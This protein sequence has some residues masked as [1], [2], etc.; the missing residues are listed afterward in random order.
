LVYK[1]VF[2]LISQFTTQIRTIVKRIHKNLD[3]NPDSKE[4]VKE[5]LHELRKLITKIALSH[6]NL[7]GSLEIETSDFWESYDGEI[8]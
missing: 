6:I 4:G 5:D 3:I 7:Y 8:G 2:P 1:E